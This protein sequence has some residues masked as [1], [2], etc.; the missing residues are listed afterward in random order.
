[1]R[2][3]VKI[4]SNGSVFA[5]A[6]TL[7]GTWFAIA[8]HQALAQST[9][10]TMKGSNPG[11]WD[12]VA[13]AKYLDDRIDLWFQRAK[14]LRTGEQKTSCV[15]CHTVV[16]Y[17]LARPALR[18]A[19]GE[20]KPTAQ[21]MKLLVETLRRVETYGTHE[22]LYKSKEEQSLGTEAVLNLLILASEDVR[23]NRVVPSEP[24]RK[25]LDELWKEQRPDGAW[26]W[27]D[28]GNE[29]FESSDSL[30]YGAALGAIA[31]GS[32]QGYSGV[33]DG[34]TPD[35]IAKLRAYLNGKYSDQ[36]LYNKIWTLLASTRLNGLLTGG[37]KATL[38]RE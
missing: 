16:P 33:A 38:I 36:S 29:P 6:S 34:N 21:E 35:H 31:V 12:K 5:L 2:K 14:K 13:V 32:V 28:F 8:S 30:Y 17:V 15:S 7:V 23:H 4:K 22:P 1:M 25:A 26:N 27:L 24:A 18:K 9:P 37:Q 19:S 11:G 20:S 10:Q 3:N